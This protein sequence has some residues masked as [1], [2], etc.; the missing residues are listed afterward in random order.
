MKNKIF[1]NSPYILLIVIPLLNSWFWRMWKLDVFTTFL[2]L[3]LSYLL[4]IS[5]I[6]KI[7]KKLMILTILATF[8]LSINSLVKGI[9]KE[10]FK[11]TQLDIS[12][13]EVRHEYYAKE[14][15]R[16]YKN[17]IGI[18]YLKKYVPNEYRIE[19]K[20]FS[21]LDLNLYFFASHPRERGGVE[22]FEKFPFVYIPFFVLGIITYLKKPKKV[23]LY[24]FLAATLTSVFIHTAYYLGPVLFFPIINSFIMLGII[25]VLKM[26]KIYE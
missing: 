20:L 19:K 2:C 25:S 18:N 21:I 24:Y 7:S 9:N 12:T 8:L 22:E 6:S 11:K 13:Y 10:L 15:G 14:L 3:V 17:R 5:L 23:F 1:Y 16:L 26:Y 4:A